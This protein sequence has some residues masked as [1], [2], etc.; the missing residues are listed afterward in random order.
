MVLD[1]N[2]KK[3]KYS[4]WTKIICILLSFI[5]FV[6]AS[7]LT[8]T[9]IFTAAYV[10]RSSDAKEW[11][12][13]SYFENMFINDVNEI[14]GNSYQSQYNDDIRDVFAS[15]KESAVEEVYKQYL[16]QKELIIRRDIGAYYSGYDESTTML[17]IDKEISVDVFSDMDENDK[18]NLFSKPGKFSIM[19]EDVYE[20]SNN[21]EAT[22]KAYIAELYDTYTEQFINN[23]WYINEDTFGDSLCYQVDYGNYQGSNA[24][25]DVNDVYNKN[26]YF[27]F[28]D[29]EI[30]YGGIPEELANRIYDS[31]FDNDYAKEVNLYLYLNDYPGRHNMISNMHYWNDKYFA[32][33]DF[34]LFALSFKDKL[35]SVIVADVIMAIISFVTS[36]YYFFITGK[37]KE[38]DDAKLSFIDKVP[39][40]IHLG[41]WAGIAVGAYV[42]GFNLL[43]DVISEYSV[44]TMIA[45]ILFAAGCW[46]FAFEF[47]ASVARYCRSGRKFYNNFILYHI[48]KLGVKGVKA[49]AKVLSYK[50]EKFK[51][52][53][54]IISLLLVLGNL[55]AL[56]LIV[57]FLCI[58]NVFCF[59]IAILLSLALI[60]ADI[61]L[62]INILKYIKN[63][64]RIICCASRREDV[65]V[66]LDM[67]KLPQSLRTLAESMKYTNEELT[68]AVSKAVRDERLK[69]ELITNVSHDLKTPL[70]SIITY[71]DLLSKC[72]IEDEKAKE[73]IAVL[74]EKGGKLKRLIEDLIEASKVTTGNVKVNAT[75]INLY[76]LCL[77]AVGES[78]QEF[79]KVNLDLLVKENEDAPIVFADGAKAFRIM[80]NLLANA[81]KYSAAHTRVYVSVYKEQGMGVF[82]IK[83][84]SAQALD[85]SPDELTQRFVRGDKSRTQDGNGLGLSI[86]KELCKIQNGRLELSIDGD[87]F[88]AKVYL[89][90]SSN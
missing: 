74:D 41:L 10:A 6:A 25:F 12:Q 29:G 72:D 16:E 46:V 38:D 71:V 85:I 78:Q 66:N 18:E 47:C 81:R 57:L 15:R 45:M 73:Y 37:K 64:D 62:F 55:A 56:A 33:Q 44:I 80:E 7:G 86:A 30:K 68:A 2:V 40:I 9:A 27:V 23:P 90:L 89:P 58:N 65:A 48:G 26:V 14:V 34:S 11:T 24:E 21:D 79:E 13:T 39:Y 84:I 77:Q 61:Y 70:T 8:V 76:E 59:V 50:P 88:K 51:K 82:E 5:T 83:N 42:L 3:Y 67:E 17:N 54:I 60:G 49:T 87:L 75:S 20:Y 1:T 63:L 4:V 36:F 53:V 69:T 22:E 19:P 31:V 28:E 32:L 52:N 35:A 43:Y